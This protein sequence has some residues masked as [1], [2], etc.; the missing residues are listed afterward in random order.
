[1]GLLTLL[2]LALLILGRVLGLLVL[3]LLA[4]LF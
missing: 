1:L 2:I 3:T 4:T